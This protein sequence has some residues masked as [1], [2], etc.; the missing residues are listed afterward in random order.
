MKRLLF[1][2]F[3]LFVPFI[4]MAQQSQLPQYVVFQ[5]TPKTA[6]VVIGDKSVATDSDGLAIFKL[7]N[8]TYS[9]VI[10]AN[11]YH[12]E[13]GAIEVYGST[14]GENWTLITTIECTT[15]YT[16]YVVDLGDAAYTFIKLA[17]VKGQ[18]R[19]AS[20]TIELG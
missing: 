6:T 11:E 8:G 7:N 2:T 10:S 14:D 5:V 18:A 12:N 4:V 13:S 16:D 15:T 20:V 1:Y 17:A 19:V 9:Y 3:A